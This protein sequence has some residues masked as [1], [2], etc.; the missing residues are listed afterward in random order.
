MIKGTDL[1]GLGK[2]AV[3]ASMVNDIDITTATNA[4]WDY[5]Y[6]YIVSATTILAHSWGVSDNY[7]VQETISMVLEKALKFKDNYNPAFCL[8]TWLSTIIKNTFIYN[9]EKGYERRQRMLSITD[10]E[11]RLIV[12]MADEDNMNGG[13]GH[14]LNMIYNYLDGLNKEDRTIMV[15]TLNGFSSAQIAK[16]IHKTENAVNIAK[17]RIRKKIRQ[18]MRDSV[19]EVLFQTA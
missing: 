10:Q 18:D 11:D 15:W 14:A 12:D 16:E 5:L 19:L 8:T 13:T 2:T 9:I 6:S 7:L 17:C 1:K 4:D 3:S